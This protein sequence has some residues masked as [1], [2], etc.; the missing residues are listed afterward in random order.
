MINLAVINLKTII[1]KIIKILIFILAIVIVAKLGI[2]FYAFYKNFD[3]DKFDSNNNLNIIKNN[4]IIEKSFKN[5]TEIIEGNSNLK[6]FLIAE[7]SI[8]SGIEKNKT[9][10]TEN[11]EALQHIAEVPN[12]ETIETLPNNEEIKE[13]VEKNNDLEEK[14]I[15]DTEK[16]SVQTSIIEQ[17]NTKEVYTDIYKSVKIKNESK[18]SLTE[19]MLTPNL[20]YSDNQ[21]IIIYHTHTCESYTKS[22]ISNYEMTGNFRT[23]DINFSV[24]RVGQELANYLAVKGYN[25]VHDKNYHDYPAFTGSYNR[26][27]STITNLLKTYNTVDCVFD[28]HRDA[29]GNQGTYAP[30]VKIGDEIVAQLM[31][32]IGTDGGGLTH[33]NWNKNL[34][35]A[36]KVQEKANEIYPGLFKPII[37]RDSRYNQHVTDGAAIIEV[38]A[39]G[40]T[41]EQAIGS[42]KFF[43][44]IL[45]LVMKE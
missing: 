10:I 11:N 29:I 4:L 20:K 38:G 34:K 8:F 2:M 28:I 15:D 9:E 25:V 13:S 44:E 32:V 27:L 30:C 45:D 5:N 31:F 17:N 33:P 40:N 1:K 3:F 19:D 6:K 14:I 37:L 18:Y 39:T 12:T 26:S 23:T 16:E 42:M 22:E 21:N 7:L 36:I 41:L 24:A 43:S 35:M